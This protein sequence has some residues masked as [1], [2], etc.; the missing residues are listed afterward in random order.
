MLSFMCYTGEVHNN[1]RQIALPRYDSCVVSYR[2][3]MSRKGHKEVALGSAGREAGSFALVLFLPLIRFGLELIQY[4][5]VKKVQ[6]Y[7]CVK[8]RLYFPRMVSTVHKL[9]KI[10]I[11][12]GE[13]YKIFPRVIIHICMVSSV[14]RYRT[15]WYTYIFVFLDVVLLLGSVLGV[16]S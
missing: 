13:R 11:R 8:R 16:D 7:Y 6:K 3:V 10:M 4:T 15:A 2:R 1:N 14:G 9:S 12:F 5:A